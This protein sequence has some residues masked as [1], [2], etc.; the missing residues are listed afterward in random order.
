MG[1]GRPGVAG[2]PSPAPA[3]GSRIAGYRLEEEIGAGGMAVVF[4]AADERLGR[5]VALKILAPWLAADDAFRHRFLRESR[6]A[7]AVDDP[8]IIPVY[9]AGEADGVLFIAMRHVSGGSVRDLLQRE[10]PLPAARV[11]AIISPLASALDAAFELLAGVVPFDREQD[12]AVI[13]AHLS[14]PPPSLAS[15]RPGLAPAAD[16]VLAGGMAKAPADRYRSCGEFAEALRRGGGGWNGR[17]IRP[18]MTPEHRWPS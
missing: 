2:G 11:A 8:Y 3:A 4:R 1:E 9:E 17:S 10:G 15:L 13:Y 12:M 6:A 14:T 16:D 18:P 5:L 7:A